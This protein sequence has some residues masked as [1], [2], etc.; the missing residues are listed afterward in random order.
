[1]SV[2]LALLIEAFLLQQ[3]KSARKKGRT[4]LRPRFAG[5][6]FAASV[7][8]LTLGNKFDYREARETGSFRV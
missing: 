6:G 1:M 4:R 7:S 5:G 8:S 2:F 3:V